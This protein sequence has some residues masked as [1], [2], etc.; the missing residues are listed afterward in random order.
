MRAD[1]FNGGKENKQVSLDF[2]A[3]PGGAFLNA[4]PCVWHVDLQISTDIR[5]ISLPM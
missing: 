2:C 4:A 5:G 1:I 3:D